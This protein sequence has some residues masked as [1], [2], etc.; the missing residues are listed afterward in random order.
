MFIRCILQQNAT[1]MQHQ[2]TSDPIPVKIWVKKFIE[3]GNVIKPYVLTACY[4]L[5]S[6]QP[7]LDKDV[8]LCEYEHTVKLPLP[9]G[10]FLNKGWM[11]TRQNIAVFNTLMEGYIKDRFE[12]ELEAN[13][14]RSQRDGE[15]FFVREMVND[16][17]ADF[18]FSEEDFPFETIK[19]HLQRY[20]DKHDI[21]FQ[22]VKKLNK[23]VPFKWPNV[24]IA[25]DSLSRLDFCGQLNL[26]TRTYARLKK[27]GEL[28][29]QRVGRCEFI[30]TKTS[31]F[32]YKLKIN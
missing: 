22:S 2:Y 17:C 19:K 21:D 32:F 31:P 27:K 10:V 13:I 25:P 16:L 4:S 9:A 8:R 14:R 23:S 18:G 20:S 29:V 24:A 1:L 5:F 11:L 15:K 26:S 7:G 12:H 6:K 28:V 30:N 3:N